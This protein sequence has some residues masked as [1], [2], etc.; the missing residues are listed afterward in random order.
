MP[1]EA[2]FNH[3]LRIIPPRQSSGL[4]KLHYWLEKLEEKKENRPQINADEQ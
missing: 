3:A 2:A 1:P 4:V